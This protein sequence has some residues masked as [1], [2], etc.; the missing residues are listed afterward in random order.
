MGVDLALFRPFLDP[1]N[2]KAQLLEERLW[3]WAEINSNSAHGAGLDLMASQL[4]EAFAE[5][6]P[7]PPERI[8]LPNGPA[9]RWICRPES[10]IRIFLGGHFDTVYPPDHPF[11]TCARLDA[12]RLQGPGTADMKG[13]L[14][15]LMEALRAFES[16]P[17][18]ATIGWEVL[19]TPDEEIGSPHSAPLLE[20][21]ARR[22]TV[23][24][25]FEP[26]L[27]GRGDLVRRRPG[28]AV[29][30]LK[31][32]G[33]AAHVGR[34]FASGKSAIV[35][36]CDAIQQI[37]GLNRAGDLI[38]N[39]GS[40]QGGGPVNVVPAEAHAYL[41]VRTSDPDSALEALRGIAARVQDAHDVKLQLTGNFTR[42]P[43]PLTPEIASLFGRYQACAQA[44]NVPLEWRDT[45][46]CC[47]GNNLAACGLPNLDT[48]GVRG[49]NTHSPEEF[50]CL[51][52]LVERARIAA[53]FLMDWARQASN[54]QEPGS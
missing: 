31:A 21:A 16:S 27:P 42:P 37:H 17:F 4:E 50:V 18:A 1:L 46:G 25:I 10:P 33:R 9:L 15:V 14:L 53:L 52:S 28:S 51:D 29:F 30:C 3:R 48:L 40:I 12:N 45:G 32:T 36:L 6:C 5:W 43:K 11:Q 47:D 41:N 20:V 24:L 54:E 34:D 23:G 19:L 39:A 35:A 13:G 8:E 2:S 38:C 7:L 26:A 49:G 44:L 22:C